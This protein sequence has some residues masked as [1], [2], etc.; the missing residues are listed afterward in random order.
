VLFIVVVPAAVAVVV[1]Q[2][3]ISHSILIN[4]AALLAIVVSVACHNSIFQVV[5]TVVK[6][7]VAGVVAQTV[8]F[9]F[10]LAVQVRFVTVQLDGVHKAQDGAI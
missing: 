8:Q 4:Q 9:I 5:S 1:N 7:P 6:L 3:S 2:L 10:I